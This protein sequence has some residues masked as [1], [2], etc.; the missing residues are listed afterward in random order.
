MQEYKED[1]NLITQFKIGGVQL[2]L[3]MLR[4]VLATKAVYIQRSLIPAKLSSFNDQYSNLLLDSFVQLI[5]E[6]G[7]K[8]QLTEDQRIQACL[9]IKDGG[10]ELGS[11]T[12]IS[13]AAYLASWITTYTTLMDTFGENKQ[14]DINNSCYA[15]AAD[16]A[17]QWHTDMVSELNELSTESQSPRFTPTVWKDTVSKKKRP[18][19]QQ[20]EIAQP[21]SPHSRAVLLQ[22]YKEQS[23]LEDSDDVDEAYRRQRLD[24]INRLS[25]L[26]QHGSSEWLRGIPKNINNRSGMPPTIDHT[27]VLSNQQMLIATHIRL[28]L[29]L[30]ISTSDLRCITCS[31]NP[32]IGEHCEHFCESCSAANAPRTG[33]HNRQVSALCD[34]IRA[35]KKP[36]QQEHCCDINKDLRTD[37]RICALPLEDGSNPS[38]VVHIDY[39]VVY[40]STTLE[41]LQKRVEEKKRKYADASRIDYG[42]D[43]FLPLVVN[44][45]GA[46]HKN[47]SNMISVLAKIAAEKTMGIHQSVYMDYWYR[48]ISIAFQKSLADALIN[49]TPSQPLSSPMVSD[50]DQ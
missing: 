29:P 11:Q 18:R 38:G 49:Y 14:H 19:K 3:I 22:K 27:M 16:E 43:V 21:I 26:T 36:H 34:L 13:S 12:A 30:H 46:Q 1:G 9:K 4:L 24:D 32:L 17:Q 48:R 23:T 39:T 41:A 25:S 47:L 15:Q 10:F 35:A 28:G 50:F 2:Q 20:E 31:D 7:L 42:A 33:H 8:L 40:S 6:P 5:N 37:I 44:R 45:Y